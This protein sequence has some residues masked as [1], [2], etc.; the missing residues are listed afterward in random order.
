MA[1]VSG[2]SVYHLIRIF[3]A[4]TGETLGSYMKKRQLAGA[5][6][7]LLNSRKRVLDIAL[8]SGFSSSEAFS[9]AFKAVYGLSPHTFRKRGASP[10]VGFERPLDAEQLRHRTAGITLRPQ[11]ET[12]GAIRLAGIRGRTGTPG[13]ALPGL[14]ARWNQLR[15]DQP[16]LSGGRAFGVCET[17]AADVCFGSDGRAL[18]CEFVGVEI[19][20]LS[21]LP[22]GLCLKTLPGGAYAVF[23][24]TG[25]AA[26][27]SKTYD[28]IWGSWTLT[29]EEVL[30][31]RE[32][33]EVYGARF[34]GAENPESQID[35]Y[36]PVK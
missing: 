9:R 18:Y 17:G 23:T 16:C 32:D 36:I 30:D 20:A 14:W 4:A 10:Y 21:P 8:E 33:F 2:Y 13:T 26:S 22:A 35:I 11:L 34:L 12:L 3:A 15:A 1:R 19:G 5:A 31:D 6:E 28:Y 7:T 25:P 29:T 24:H 27:L